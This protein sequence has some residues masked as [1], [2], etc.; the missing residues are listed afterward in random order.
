MTALECLSEISMV[1][2]DE[3]FLIIEHSKFCRYEK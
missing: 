2:K 3:I 1:S